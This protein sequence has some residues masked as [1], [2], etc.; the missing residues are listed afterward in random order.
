MLHVEIFL[1]TYHAMPC[2][3]I[4]YHTKD[5]NNFLFTSRYVVQGHC[6]ILGERNNMN[7][8]AFGHLYTFEITEDLIWNTKNMEYFFFLVRKRMHSYNG[9]KLSRNSPCT[10]AAHPRPFFQTFFFFFFFL[11]LVNSLI[12]MNPVFC[13]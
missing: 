2:Y 7:C 4:P 3:I 8:H 9:I 6:I 12:L 11:P 5:G 10:L 1:Q 13:P